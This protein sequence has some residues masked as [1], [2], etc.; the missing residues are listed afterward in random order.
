MRNLRTSLLTRC[1]K[2]L[3]YI[4]AHAAI[5]ATSAST[6]GYICLFYTS[7][8]LWLAAMAA[9]MFSVCCDEADMARESIC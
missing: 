1:E 2:L 5:T 9:V 7:T 4:M 8:V 6:R 3:K